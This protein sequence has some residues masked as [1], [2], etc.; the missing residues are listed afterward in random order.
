MIDNYVLDEALK[1]KDKEIEK[2]NIKFEDQ[3][4]NYEQKIK[5]LMSSIGMLKADN[6]NL[7]MISKDNVRVNI[8]NNMKKELK[9]KESVI[10]LLRKMIGDEEKVDKYLLKEF[11][12]QGEGRLPSFEDMKIKVRQL[13]GEILTMKHKLSNS[14]TKA[15]TEDNP[16]NTGVFIKQIEQFKE[17]NE[18]LQSEL[19]CLQNDNLTLKVN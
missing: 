15:K 10:N 12:K 6:S 3:K 18:K 1:K 11:G 13:E 8:I 16:D 19:V 9:D 2:I 4:K 14:L 17:H 5:N 7:E